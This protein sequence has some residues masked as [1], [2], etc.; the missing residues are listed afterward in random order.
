MTDTVRA[1]KTAMISR[2]TMKRPMGFPARVHV[3]HKATARIIGGAG[4]ADNLRSRAALTC[5]VRHG[6]VACGHPLRRAAF[7]HA[8]APGKAK[9]KLFHNFAKIVLDTIITKMHPGPNLLIGGDVS[10]D[11]PEAKQGA[12]PAGPVSS[13]VTRE[14]REISRQALRPVRGV[15]LIGSHVQ[16]RGDP[17]QSFESSLGLAK[18]SS[19]RFTKAAA[20]AP[21]GAINL[22]AP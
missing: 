15:E 21:K 22:S 6:A 13:P 1:T 18:H 14:P 5:P 17:V 9:P 7:G 19:E 2:R 8:P 3:I 4:N 20:G 11:D 10:R 12:V 16:S